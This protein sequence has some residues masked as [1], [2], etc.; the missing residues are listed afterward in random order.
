MS[1]TA[2]TVKSKLNRMN[3][4]AQ[5]TESTSI[6][7][8]ESVFSTFTKGD[9]DTIVRDLIDQVYFSSFPKIDASKSLSA[10]SMNSSNV[11]FLRKAG[12]LGVVVEML[13]QI[14]ETDDPN[15]NH[16]RDLVRTLNILA[17]D[18][19][20][21]QKLLT[22]PHAIPSLMKLCKLTTGIIQQQVFQIIERLC[23]VNGG[24]ETLLRNNIFNLLLSQE[25]LC[26]NTTSLAIRHSTASYVSKIATYNPSEFPILRMEQIAY[27]DGKRCVDGYIEMQLLNAMLA[28]LTYLTNENVHFTGCVDIFVHLVKEIKFELFEDL[29]HLLQILKCLMIISKEKY[30]GAYLLKNDLGIALQYVVRTDFELWR[31]VVQQNKSRAESGHDDKKSK[32]SDEKKSLSLGTANTLLAIK[33]IAQASKSK[34]DDINFK[35]TRIVVQIY[36][37]LLKIGLHAVED[38]MSS[39]LVSGLLFRVGKGKN[40]DKRFHKIVVHFLYLL[41]TRVGIDQPVYSRPMSVIT[42]VPKPTMYVRGG[43]SNIP[44]IK[45]VS[46][47]TPQKA[48]IDIRSITN[49]FHAQG[50]TFLLLSCLDSEDNEIISEALT[51][52][53]TMNF[54]VIKADVTVPAVI[55]KI[56]FF[57]TS[58]QDCFFSGLALLCDTIQTS[59]TPTLLEE[60]M[61]DYK[62]LS[63]LVK[64]LKLS[65]W[66]FTMKAKVYDALA[67]LSAHSQFRDKMFKLRGTSVLSYEMDARKKK[68]RIHRRRGD[69]GTEEVSDPYTEMLFVSMKRDW[70]AI[71]IQALFRAQQT[72][73]KRK[74]NALVAGT[75]YS[76]IGDYYGSADILDGAL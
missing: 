23:H 48:I 16:I 18:S 51:S 14:Q 3:A 62:V 65:G 25:M 53:A 7:S 6:P 42:L 27:P 26:R 70:A 67:L 4:I 36:E 55:G 8:I 41:L 21:Q 9:D 68:N 28:H 63:I 75:R 50:V 40:V 29:A 32:R 45:A 24:I 74:R 33:S 54:S 38:I 49:K 22:N 44:G 58:R 43:M 20:V 19:A 39:G 59:L 13:R 34:I 56:S 1:W 11:Q 31:K 35:T 15:S 10:L 60:V 72:R 66:I 69:G 37:N 73:N 30:Y 47:L 71:K 5:R 52:L 12:S 57:A 2:G 61:S 64:A 17:D 76:S 46:T